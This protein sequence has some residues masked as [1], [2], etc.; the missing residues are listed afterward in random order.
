MG[1]PCSSRVCVFECCP[2]VLEPQCREITNLG[3]SAK[4][5]VILGGYRA[6]GERFGVLSP[7]PVESCIGTRKHDSPWHIALFLLEE[8]PCRVGGEVGPIWI[9]PQDVSN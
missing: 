5:S 3:R 9:E 1:V 8:I 7:V 4:N 6:K 2:V